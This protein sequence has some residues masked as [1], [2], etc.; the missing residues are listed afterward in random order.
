MWRGGLVLSD[1][2]KLLSNN[3]MG[4][5]T[6][7]ITAIF[8]YIGFMFKKMIYNFILDKTKKEIVDKTVKYVEQT[9]KNLSCGE[10]KSLALKKSLEW[11]K[12][13]KIKVSSTELEI[14]IES[15]VNCL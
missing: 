6:T 14:L 7:I 9:G 2:V 8:S 3:L 13:K 10:K 1:I 4:F 11:L 12:E 15:A 5:L